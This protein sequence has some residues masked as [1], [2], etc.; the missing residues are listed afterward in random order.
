M[1][2]SGTRYRYVCGGTAGGRRQNLSLSQDETHEPSRI[3]LA[4]WK[5]MTTHRY[6]RRILDESIAS[7]HIQPDPD[8]P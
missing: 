3:L 8:C 4:Q 1:A 6:A 2:L 7:S 5:V